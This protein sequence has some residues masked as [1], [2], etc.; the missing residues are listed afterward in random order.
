MGFEQGQMMRELGAALLVTDIKQKRE[1]L[2]QT[3]K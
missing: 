1:T 2:T 3:A